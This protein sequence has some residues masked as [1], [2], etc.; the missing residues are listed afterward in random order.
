MSGPLFMRLAEAGNC[1]AHSPLTTPY[2]SND[3]GFCP[4]GAENCPNSQVLP[5][6]ICRRSGGGSSTNCV[7]GYQNG[8]RLYAQVVGGAIMSQICL[9]VGQAFPSRGRQGGSEDCL[10]HPPSGKV[11]VF[12]IKAHKSTRFL[13]PFIAQPQQGRQRKL[14][15]LYVGLPEWLGAPTE[16]LQ[17]GSY[18]CA[19][20][21]LWG[22]VGSSQKRIFFFLPAYWSN[23]V[24]FIPFFPS[25]VLWYISVLF[26][27]CLFLNV[28]SLYLTQTKFNQYFYPPEQYN[29]CKLI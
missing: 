7:H 4:L 2:L 20:D 16:M 13:A 24:F 6:P 19:R 17:Q 15:L 14:E 3:S 27:Q 25:F 22:K 12:V 21:L 5:W 11:A 29:D 26:F 28:Y 18:S 9:Q 10:P 8:Y 23:Q 1:G